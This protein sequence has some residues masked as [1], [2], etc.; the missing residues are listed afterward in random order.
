MRPINIYTLTRL[1]DPARLSRLERQMSA[2]KN[3]L[4]IKSWET[5]GLKRFSEKLCAVSEETTELD[6]YYSFVMPKLGKEFDLLR[7][8]DDSI[9]NN[10]LKSGNVSDEAIRYQLMQNRY[11]LSTLS[12]TMYFYTYISNADRLVRLTGGGRLV[13]AGWTELCDLLLRQGDSFHGDIEDLFQEEKFLI[14]PL[15]DPDRFLRQEYFLTFQQRDI[16]KQILKNVTAPTIQGF[17]G[18]PG[19]GKTILLYD[20]AMQLSRRDCVCVF[21]LGSHTPELEQLDERLKRIDFYYCENGILPPVEKKY[22]AIL[23]D[24]GHRLNKNMLQDILALRDRW[25]APV[26]ISYDREDLLALSER[27]ECGA[28]IL[29]A[30]PEFLHYRLTNHIRRSSELSAFIRCVIRTGEAGAIKN[31]SY[32]AVTLSYAGDAEE[33]RRLLN[34][35]RKEGYTYI[36]NSAATP[37]KDDTTELSDMTT[38]ISDAACKEFASVVML[39]DASFFY[40]ASGYLRQKNMAAENSAA[41][42][43]DPVSHSAVRNLFHGLSRAKER[44]AI[45]VSENLPVFDTLLSFIH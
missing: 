35:Y 5:E 38:E 23:V 40:D 16:K 21:H 4:K 12:K 39:L 45:V 11:Y 43:S 17:T 34:I 41:I 15:T 24:E 7:I 13:D 27:A 33:T 42:S 9:I 14:S 20:I 29:E 44:I 2:R 1:S 18:F 30:L 19:T 26:I 25:Q 3:H 31:S 8:N 32:P 10:E 28:D 22:N 6:Y 36:R 37:D